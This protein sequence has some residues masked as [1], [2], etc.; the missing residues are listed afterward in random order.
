MLTRKIIGSTRY[1][2]IYLGLVLSFFT[3]AQS[4]VTQ[5]PII[6]STVNV[7]GKG[8]VYVEPDVAIFDLAIQTLDLDAEVATAEAKQIIEKIQNFLIAMDVEKELIRSGQ[9]NVSPFQEYNRGRATDLKYQVQHTLTITLRDITLL[10]EVLAKGLKAGANLSGGIRYS[11]SNGEEIE[12]QARAQAIEALQ[13]RLNQYVEQTGLNVGS[14]LQ[15]RESSNYNNNNNQPYGPF[16][17][18][19]PFGYN[20]YGPIGPYGG[21]VGAIG[22]INSSVLQLNVPVSPGQIAIEVLVNAVYEIK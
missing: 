2:L 11:L 12:S 4:Q 18:S 13:R 9:F 5:S 6:Q 16:G 21:P 10:S 17:P 3:M 7:S 14:I 1:L 20:L 19:G 22:P 8:T 15:I